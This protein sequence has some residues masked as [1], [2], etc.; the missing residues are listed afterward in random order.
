MKALP[1][2]LLLLFQ[3]PSVDAWVA[4]LRDESVEKREEAAR[5]LSEALGKGGGDAALFRRLAAIAAR[6]NDAEAAAQIGSLLDPWRT[7]AK[8]REREL[9]FVIDSIH[10]D[11]GDLLVLGRA[12][13]GSKLAAKRLAAGTLEELGAFELPWGSMPVQAVVSGGRAWAT[14]TRALVAIDIARGAE[15][16]RQ[17]PGRN[18]AHP[19]LT[20]GVLVV[21]GFGAMQ[22]ID[23]ATGRGL[24]KVEGKGWFNPPIA[25]GALA[26]VGRGGGVTA[27]RVADGTEAWSAPE[28]GGPWSLEGERLIVERGGRVSA[29]DPATGTPAWTWDAGQEAE[30]LG[31]GE[32]VLAARLY[33]LELPK[34][35]TKSSMDWVPGPVVG[36]ELATG[37]ELWRTAAAK[38]VHGLPSGVVVDG[39]LLGHKD[40]KP[41][42]G[43]APAPAMEAQLGSLGYRGSGTKAIAAWRAKGLDR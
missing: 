8:V 14:D 41:L 25:A 12:P 5:A 37:R 21:G 34:I 16:W 43:T 6:S 1:L 27:Y 10:V 23:P 26:W 22:G 19:V 4:Q 36:I 24:W 3:D 38:Q 18:L 42:P 13:I 20:G 9:P 33:R 28:A 39:I 7:G 2:L 29:L 30:F 17:E 32:G 31:S 15:L 11:G 40:G 35:K